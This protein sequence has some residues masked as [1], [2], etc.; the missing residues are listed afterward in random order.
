LR[1]QT[2]PEDPLNIRKPRVPELSPAGLT[3]RKISSLLASPSV[4][5]VEKMAG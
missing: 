4:D 2:L 5:V 3:G 1:F